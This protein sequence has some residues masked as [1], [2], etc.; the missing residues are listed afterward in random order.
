MAIGFRNAGQFAFVV[1][2][3]LDQVTFDKHH[4]MFW[5]GPNRLLNVAH[6]YG[7]RSR[8]GDV[9]Y[10]YEIYGMPK[11][12]LVHP[13]LRERVVAARVASID[14]LDLE[15]RNG[16][17]LSI[18]DDPDLKSWWFLDPTREEPPLPGE[19]RLPEDEEPEFLDAKDYRGKD[20]N[21][22]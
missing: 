4:V 8:S 15:F 10:V 3:E 22:R 13:I 2:W 12:G 5:F 19:P 11:E 6:S 21:S 9:S 1:G 7:L 20:S 16:Y 14:Q 17:V 18:F